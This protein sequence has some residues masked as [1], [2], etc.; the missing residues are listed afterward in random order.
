MSVAP[1]TQYARTEDG[2]SIAYQAVGDGPID[3]VL[4]PTAHC[5]D[6]MR[7]EPS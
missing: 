6:V 4:V 1:E 7:E 5:I 2:L 3:I